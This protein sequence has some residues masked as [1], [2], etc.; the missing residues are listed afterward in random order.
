MTRF[1]LNGRA[2]QVDLP[3]GEPLLQVLANDLGADGPK[4]GCG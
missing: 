2:V 3:A 4:Y 1:T